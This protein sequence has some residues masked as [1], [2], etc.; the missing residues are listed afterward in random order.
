MRIT[1]EKKE[2]T[3]RRILESAAEVFRERGFD[4]AT[5][6]ELARR[7]GVAAGTIFNY[8]P[9]KE[10]IAAGLIGESLVSHDDELRRDDARFDEVLFSFV[11]RNLR[12]LRPLRASLRGALDA[13]LSP[14]IASNST[15]GVDAI[16][17]EQVAALDALARAHGYEVEALGQ[18]L[19]WTLWIGVLCHWATTSPPPRRLARPSRL[20]RRHVL[21]LARRRVRRSTPRSSRAPPPSSKTRPSVDR[22]RSARS[23]AAGAG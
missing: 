2:A 12:A 6:R 21:S 9:S 11:A 3:R 4:D 18:Q 1:A 13:V 19:W 15:P 14:G 17:V 22:A 20:F 10:A 16:R 5:T 23:P 7:A 8:F